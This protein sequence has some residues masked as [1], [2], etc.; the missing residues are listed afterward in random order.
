MLRHDVAK[1]TNDA[2]GRITHLEHVSC[3]AMLTMD[4]ESI[5]IIDSKI[6]SIGVN[7]SQWHPDAVSKETLKDT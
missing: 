1:Q 4:T 6:G 3:F 2:M 5:C 7:H